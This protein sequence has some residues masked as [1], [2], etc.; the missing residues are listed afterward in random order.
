MSAITSL[1]VAKDISKSNC[2][3]L[4]EFLQSYR[5]GE[6]WTYLRK[7]GLPVCAKILVTETPRELEILAHT[8]GHEHLLVLLGTLRECVGIAR[9]PSRNKKL[10]CTLWSR[11]EENRGLD[12]R[13]SRLPQILIRLCCQLIAEFEAILEDS[14]ESQLQ[15]ATVGREVCTLR[16]NE[17]FGKWV[18]QVNTQQRQT[19]SIASCW[20]AR[21]KSN[22]G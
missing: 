19:V 2:S 11:L 5:K 9:P 13:K 14:V 3:G 16:D 21:S 8:G 17:V 22:A 18:E 6:G 15:V 10:S 1:P 20:E 7:L 4:E 12:V